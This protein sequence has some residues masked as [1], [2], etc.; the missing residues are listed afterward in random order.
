MGNFS[1]TRPSSS[2]QPKL[3]SNGYLLIFGPFTVPD[4]HDAYSVRQSGSPDRQ[5][6]ADC[7]LCAPGAPVCKM[8]DNKRHQEEYYVADRV[9]Y[10]QGSPAETNSQYVGDDDK[11]WMFDWQL[12]HKYTVTVT[13]STAGYSVNLYLLFCC[14][15][16]K[17]HPAKNV[18]IVVI[19]FALLPV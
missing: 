11:V 8:G 13:S 5:F 18:D 9:F 7:S 14:L 6:I 12:P 1:K 3:V 10:H 16:I 19:Y 2:I 4:I 17:L 15:C